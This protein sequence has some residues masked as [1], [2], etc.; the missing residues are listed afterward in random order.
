MSIFFR[1]LEKLC[2]W[3]K[4]D[5]CDKIKIFEPPKF[6]PFPYPK[7]Q[8]LFDS[9]MTNSVLEKIKNKKSY[10]VHFFAYL[11]G[12]KVLSIED[13]SVYSTLAA[14]HCPKVYQSLD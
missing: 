9:N 2:P 11:S 1:N 8:V 14:K 12:Q 5:A 6:F 10:A 7:W 4:R 3:K 13:K